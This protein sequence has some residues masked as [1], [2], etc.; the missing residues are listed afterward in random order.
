MIKYNG[1]YLRSDGRQHMT[2]FHK[3]K[4]TSI[5]YAK[6]LME[7]HLKRKLTIKEVVHHKDG[8]PLNNVFS[9]L[10]IK[11]RAKHSSDHVFKYPEKNELQ[12]FW[13]KRIFIINRKQMSNRM[14]ESRRGKKGPFC[15]KSCR[16]KYSTLGM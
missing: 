7:Q 13:C 11:T 9:N 1:P 12:C 6:Y 2:Y 4:K 14:R 15:S 16:G 3:G 10:E 8:N 5:S